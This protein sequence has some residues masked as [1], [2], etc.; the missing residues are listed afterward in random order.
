MMIL[1]RTCVA[2]VANT[3]S[4]YTADVEIKLTTGFNTLIPFA[5]YNKVR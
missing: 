5:V 4:A 1:T 2:I 3:V